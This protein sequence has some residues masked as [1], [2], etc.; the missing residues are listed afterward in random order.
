MQEQTNT[1]ELKDR[2]ELIENMLSAGRRK[3]ESWGWVFVLW[4][5]AYYIAIAWSSWGNSLRLFSHLAWPVTMLTACLLTMV[6]AFSRKRNEPETTMGRAI[7]SIWFSVGISMLLL[8]PSLSMAHKLDQ[9]SFVALI[10][11]MLAIANGASGMILKW[12]AQIGC[13]VVWWITSVA[14]VF[15]SVAQVTILFLATLTVCQIGFGIY[16]MTRESKRRHEA[17]HA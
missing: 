2:L 7:G 3:T 6:I 8:F 4:G 1:Q 17:V 9:Q 11:V 5:V 12:R 10:A 16:A 13:S 15:C 14:A